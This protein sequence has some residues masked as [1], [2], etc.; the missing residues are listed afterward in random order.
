MR[1]KAYNAM[2]EE[3]NKAGGILGRQVEVLYYRFDAASS[4]PIDQQAQAACAHWTQDNK[5]F[6]ILWSDANGVLRECAARAGAIL[7]LWDT[8]MAAL[9]EDF[10]TYPN[11]VEISGLD[12]VRAGQVTVVGLH[13]EGYFKGAKLGVIM[14]DGPDYKAAFERGFVPALRD[15][16]IELA[17]EPAYASIPQSAQDLAATSADINNAVLR[18]QSQGITHVM[19]LDGPA[20]LCGGACLGTLFMR[21]AEQQSYRPR[22]GFNSNN[23]ARSGQAQ[24]LYPVEQLPRSVAVEWADWDR[25]YDAGWKLNRAREACYEIMRKHGV[26]LTNVNEELVAR[27]ACE[28]LWFMIAAINEIGGA[29][30]NW[31]TF[32]S[33][34]N[35]IG[36][37]FQSPSAYAVNLSSSQHDGVSA[38]RNQKF[39]SSCTCYKWIDDPYRI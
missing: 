16:G 24:G 38:A 6:A 34:V 33:G 28:Q 17:T 18:F 9:P 25:T 11:F 30:L 2:V 29:T 14:W 23:V 32:I 20:G 5:V 10:E 36:G 21:R 13:R 19:I 31:R 35:R 22:Y 1:A 3:V 39:V 26:P 7:P 12:I 4:E 15:K 37:S 8:P 27:A